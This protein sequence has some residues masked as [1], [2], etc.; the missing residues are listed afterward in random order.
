ML[1][2]CDLHVEVDGQKVLKGVSLEIGES[3]VHAVFGPNGSG[4]TTLLASVMGLGKYTVTQG[5]ILFRGQDITDLSVDER[6]RLGVGMSFQR[7]PTIHGV[8]LRSLLEICDKGDVAEIDS[9]AE[10]LHVAPF[11]DREVNAGLSGGELKRVEMLQ[12]LLQKPELVF[13]DEPESGVDLENMAL[14]G[15]ASASL[16]GREAPLG[17]LCGSGCADRNGCRRDLSV[18]ELR[19]RRHKAGLLITHT[20][21]IMDYVNVDRGHVMMDGRI[22]CSGNARDILE[23]IRKNG[24][25][26]CFRCMMSEGGRV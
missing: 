2:V 9:L 26:E 22:A 18:K 21:N 24:Y 7:P 5:A 19:E 15:R 23:D 16:L 17:C 12:L 8:R 14:I 11:L 25:S 13:L 10:T 6:A 4:K 3:E 20:G 1:E